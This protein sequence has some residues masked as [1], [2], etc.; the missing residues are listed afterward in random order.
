MPKIEMEEIKLI[1][2]NGE[3]Y[4]GDRR[5][6]ERCFMNGKDIYEEFN[7]D[8]L[9]FAVSDGE[10]EQDYIKSSGSSGFEVFENTVMPKRAVMKCYVGG[11][12]NEEALMNISNLKKEC[13]KCLIQLEMHRLEYPAVLISSATELTGVDYFYLITIEF[14][15]ITRFPLVEMSIT[16]NTIFF[17]EGNTSSGVK[18]EIKPI[19]VVNNFRIHGIAINRIDAGHTFI[20]DGMKCTVMDNGVNRFADTDL[21]AFP[22]INGGRNEII[23]S[24]SVPV[25]VSFYPVFF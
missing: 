11:P 13:M 4:E 25:K 19:R 2:F 24:E 5:T 23:M 12:S 6:G 10:I 14:S 9:E 16:G 3:Y 17:N 15:V 22:E 18:F 7:A 1:V 8:V 20:I 21:M